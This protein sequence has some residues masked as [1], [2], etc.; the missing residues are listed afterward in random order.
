QH[1]RWRPHRIRRPLH[2]IIPPPLQHNPALRILQPKENHNHTNRHARIQ[3]S[4]QNVI[5]PHPP[6]E[7]VP[8]HNIVEDEP[9][10]GPRGVV[11]PCRGRDRTDAGE[12]DGD[13]DVAEE[14]KRI[15]TGEEEERDRSE[16]SNQEEPQERTIPT[17]LSEN[18]KNF[19]RQLTSHPNRRA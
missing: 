12:E 16:S 4:R 9:R 3:R 5:I 11:E 7:M 1:I 8:P 15:P 13:V 2:Y 18:F 19:K 10:Y 17:Q 6:P 14:G